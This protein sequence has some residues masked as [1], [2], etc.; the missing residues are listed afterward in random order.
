MPRFVTHEALASNILNIRHCSAQGPTLPWQQ[1]LTNTLELL[2][3]MVARMENDWCA[4]APRARKAWNGAGCDTD[5]NLI[6][7]H[8][9]LLLAFFMGLSIPTCPWGLQGSFAK[10]LRRVPGVR[11]SFQDPGP[12]ELCQSTFARNRENV[13]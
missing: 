13:S 1:F 3:L 8:G 5:L 11:G 7:L 12:N 10:D 4:S 9:S 6:Y 2:Q